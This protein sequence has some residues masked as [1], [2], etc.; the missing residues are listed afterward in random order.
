MSTP[1]ETPRRRR[2]TLASTHRLEGGSRHPPAAKIYRNLLILEDLLR[3]LAAQQAAL[4]KKYIWALLFLVMTAVWLFLAIQLDPTPGRKLLYQF[5]FYVLCVT[6]VLFRLLG[7]YHHKIV[8]PKRFVVT[9]NKGL[10]QLNLRLVKL[11]ASRLERVIDL[12][13]QVLGLVARGLLDTLEFY[14]P[15]LLARHTH[16]ARL[17]ARTVTEWVY[18]KLAYIDRVCQ[19][20]IGFNDVK[21]VL[22]PRK[23]ETTLRQGWEIYRN[24]F[25]AREG[26]KR[27]QGEES[28]PSAKD[29]PQ[30]P[31]DL[32]VHSRPSTPG[33]GRRRGRPRML[34]TDGTRGLRL[35]GE[36]RQRL[37]RTSMSEDERGTPP[38]PPHSPLL[39]AHPR[40][41]PLMGSPDRFEST[42][43]VS[44]SEGERSDH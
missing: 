11:K 32:P 10:R 9:A 28:I 29:Q 30:W 16:G 39:P 27:R 22:N 12:C 21:L 41:S 34:L 33:A 31:R 14:Y 37:P 5:A 6:L 35:D 3:E 40:L 36:T 4:R 1:A 43:V 38:S 8:M 17:L 20:R 13:R 2:R 26:Y 25:W 7:E 44:D 23:F 15:R 42:A 19:P 24:D 18:M